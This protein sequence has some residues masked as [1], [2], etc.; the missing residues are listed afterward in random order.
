MTAVPTA[1]ASSVKLT[2]RPASAKLSLLFVSVAVRI[3][4]A[5]VAAVTSGAT[6]VVAA[7]ADNETVRLPEPLEAE[8]FVSPAKDAPMA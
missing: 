7:G 8:Y 4:L 2:V 1:V 6:R 5:P 3:A